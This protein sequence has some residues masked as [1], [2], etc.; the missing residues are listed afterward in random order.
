MTGVV[1]LAV[2]GPV[3]VRGAAGPFR[4]PAALELAVYLAFHRG[5]VRPGDWSLALWPDRAVTAATVHST[6]SDCRRALGRASDGTL[7]L[8]R[9]GDLVLRETVRTDVERFAALARSG[10]PGGVLEA[11]ALIRG[12]LFCGLRRTDWAIFDGTASRMEELVAGTA[13]D[14][15]ERLIG[16]GRGRDAERVVRQALRISPYD[17]RLH[18]ALLHALDAQGNRLGLR[19]A[20]A[21]LRSLAGSPGG[22]HPETT[23][24]YQ[25]LVGFGAAAGGHPA[26]L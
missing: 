11:M 24:L 4:R 21:Q 6:A 16:C 18:R 23:L 2:L 19:T 15:A 26:R 7:H 12:P 20:M 8:P 13:L 3:A 22:L 14:G 10:D 9:G 17:E 1:E 25:R 5:A